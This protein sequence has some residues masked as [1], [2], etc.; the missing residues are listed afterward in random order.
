MEEFQ[1]LLNTLKRL[2]GPGGCPWDHE[3]TLQSLRHTL[4]EETFEVVEAIDLDD[5]RSIKEELGDLLFNAFFLCIVAE[6]E[7][8]FTFQE[9]LQA[10][11]SKLI[12]RHP[13]VFG[14]TSLKTSEEVVQQWEA[15]KKEEKKTERKSALDGIPKD[16]P[17]LARG[18]KMAKKLAG[19]LFS[20]SKG[21]EMSA[22]DKAGEFL[23]EI[24]QTLS[25]QGI[26]AEHALRKRLSQIETEFRAWEK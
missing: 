7:Q 14:D 25:Q 20:A 2:I 16:L 18:Q 19:K 11:I 23:W 1:I 17:A 4:V 3:Q 8:R 15:I 13:H 10:I 24:V 21:P 12:H 6:K 5:N 9:A 26:Q 22:E